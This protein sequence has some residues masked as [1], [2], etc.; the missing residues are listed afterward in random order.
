MSD[1]QDKN[2]E[3]SKRIHKLKKP[4][5]IER[6]A[7]EEYGMV[8][9]GEEAYAILPAPTPVALPDVWPFAGVAEALNR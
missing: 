6:M 4:E 9:P 8:R 7:R 1:L 2:E 3:P 5:E